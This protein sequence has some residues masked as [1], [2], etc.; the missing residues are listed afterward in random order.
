MS[1]SSFGKRIWTVLKIS[2]PAA[3][4][5]L[6]G[7]VQSM[8]D[9]LFVGRISSVS[10]A[11]VGV[12]MQYVGMLYAF[13]SL[14]YVGTNAL[15][16]RFFGAKDP[17]KAGLVSYNMFVLALAFSVPLFVVGF[18]KSHVL[19]N[20][21]GMSGEIEEIG[22]VYMKI[23][24]FSIPVLFAQGVLYSSLN[25]YGKTKIPFYIGIFGNIVNFLLD[26]ALIFGAW[27]FPAL[28]VAGVAYATVIA[29]LLEFFIYA[30]LCFIRKEIDFVMRFSGD[31]LRRALKVGFP[32]WMERMMTFPTYIV[33]SALVAR[34]GTEAL[35]GY[36]IGL[37][38]EGIAFMP[39]VGFIV[40]TMALTG[41]HLGAGNPEEAEKD[42]MAATV[43]AC[44]FMGTVGLLMFLF[45][46][47]LARMFTTDAATVESAAEYLRIMGL[48]Q[49]PLGIFF[50]MSGALRGAGDTRT[51]FI[52]NT[53]CIW[54]LRVL[55]AAVMVW[56]GI[57]L[58]WVYLVAA[59]ESA[60]RAG[61]LVRVFLRGRW[62]SIAV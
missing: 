3:M 11:A 55:P 37:R 10:V 61:L 5:N 31:L 6:L 33:L 14:F 56:A 52:V 62:K 43:A 34:Y 17:E 38:I 48:S 8:V 29:R 41:R 7:M 51:T 25:A 23:Y 46:S 19:F 30:Y 36:Q 42:A 49:I 12:S 59:L 22:S 18:Y 40:A 58:F 50:V 13:M 20:I 2:F 28:G 16:S 60:V 54:L 57:A 39:G 4:Y 1:D 32:T 44:A 9:M 26:Y 47:P 53:A 21:L 35:A 45:P 27:G 24:C 15:V